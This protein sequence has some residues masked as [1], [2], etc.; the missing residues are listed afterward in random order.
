MSIENG[1]GSD[2]KVV[3]I[4]VFESPS[5][6]LFEDHFNNMSADWIEGSGSFTH[7][8]TNNHWVVSNDGHDEWDSFKY[9]FNDDQKE[10]LLNLACSANDPV[11]K[12]IAGNSSGNS[13]LNVSLSDSTGRNVDNY[14]ST[15]LELTP[16]TSVY[17]I[18]FDGHF[19]NTYGASPGV[20]NERLISNLS[21]SINGGFASYPYTG[22]NATYNSFYAG[23][24]HI[25]WIGIG[26]DG[27]VP[28]NVISG[29]NSEFI[30][31]ASVFP[32]PFVSSF[33]LSLSSDA[34]GIV[35][36]VN[37]QGVVLYNSPY[38][39][40][41]EIGVELTKGFYTVTLTTEKGVEVFSVIKN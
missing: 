2:S 12:V 19:T 20:V 3:A 41:E 23:D 39:G 27:C 33:K 40:Q 18:D 8:E 32:N 1:N 37:N 22:T 31:R 34:K 4:E 30:N 26:G 13:V 5:G 38:N 28:P 7:T 25:D 9:F 15:L 6:C 17:E 11:V 16:T 10:E 29:V 35:Q 21:F 24:V 14:G 36:I